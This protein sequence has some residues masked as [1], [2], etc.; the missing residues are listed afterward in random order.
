MVEY[1]EDDLACSYFKE[2]K[3]IIP[4]A[5][6]FK[7]VGQAKK[8]VLLI[9]GYLGYPGELVR[10]AIDLANQGFDVYVPRL[11]GMGTMKKF[12][13]KV[14][15]DICLDYLTKFYAG[16]SKK[17]TNI[18]VL[19]HSAGSVLAVMLA[20][21]VKCNRLV[22]V[23]P[24]FSMPQFKPFPIYASSLFRTAIKVKWQSD[25]SFNLHYE[26]ES[27]DQLLGKQYWSFFFPRVALSLL[28]MQNDALK[29]IK[30]LKNDTLIITCAL[31]DITDGSVCSSLIKKKKG[32]NSIVEISNAT[33]FVFYD[34]DPKAEE[35]AVVKCLEF[36]L[37]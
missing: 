15:Y 4:A 29:T 21:K 25:P 17:Y 35:T 26:G 13:K 6:P 2:Y 16:I 1:F 32:K 34:R 31:D 24:A 7:I 23:A 5:R 19:G 18:D 28:K 30:K 33:H 12:A 8:A 10:P 37:K 20:K 3:C 27:N 22:L 36:L 14:R 9:H 11:P